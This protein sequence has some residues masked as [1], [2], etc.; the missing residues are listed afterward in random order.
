MSTGFE[1]LDHGG[2]LRLRGRGR[3]AGEAAAGVLR[4][5]W[6]AM[7]GQAPAPGPER[8]E[9]WRAPA[10][11]PGAMALVELVS[12][13][14]YRA[15]VTGEA[16]VALDGEPGEGRVGLAALPGGLRPSREVKAVTYNEPRLQRLPG[17]SW[18]AEVTVDL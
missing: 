2:D 6:A 8:W 13:A 9:P 15:V 14:L 12:E 11:L 7:F 1:L 4:A 17:G 5:L 16:V 18:V 3:T 10:S